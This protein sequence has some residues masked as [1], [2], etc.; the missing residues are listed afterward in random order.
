[1]ELKYLKSN[2]IK[3]VFELMKKWHI[4][5]VQISVIKT[6]HYDVFFNYSDGGANISV[7]DIASGRLVEFFRAFNVKELL[8][9]FKE[10]K[11]Y[12][13]KISWEGAEMYDKNSK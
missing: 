6:W 5:S 10:S 9:K 3:N 7:Y 12:G 1:M 4:D 13:T 8:E 11:Y 2:Y